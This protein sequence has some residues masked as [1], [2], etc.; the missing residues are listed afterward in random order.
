MLL[1]LVLVADIIIGFFAFYNPDRGFVFDWLA[2]GQVSQTINVPAEPKPAAEPTI[3]LP[4]YEQKLTEL[5]ARGLD[6]LE[7]DLEQMRLRFYRQ[8]RL[9]HESAISAKGDPQEWGGS[10]VGLYKI[11]RGYKQAFSGLAEV[12]M[13]FAL[14]YYGKYYLH[15]EPFYPSGTK[16]VSEFSGGCISQTDQDAEFTYNNVDI[17]MP[18]L[19]VDKNKDE[20]EYTPSE[21]A[22][23][24]EISAAS[25]L[26]ADLDSGFVFGQKEQAT[27]RPIASLTKLMTAAVVVESLDL[28]KRI[29]AS[30]E[31]LTAYGETAG[32]TAGSRYGLVELLYPLLIQSSNDA[33][34]VLGGFLGRA[35]TLRKMDEKA[36]AIMMPDTKFSDL[37]GFDPGNISSAQ[38]L[39]YLA[40]YILNNRPLLW[41]ITRGQLVRSFGEVQF[42]LAKLWNK[43]IFAGDPTFI[44]GKTGYI[45]ASGYNSLFIFRLA[46]PQGQQRNVAII[47]LG[48]AGL[49]LSKTETQKIYR[50]LLDNYFDPTQPQLEIPVEQP[51]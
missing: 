38:D 27:V 6:F 44:G 19:V 51:R 4:L 45:K 49:E 35:N 48:G 28:R 42:E 25:Y 26:V 14:S 1:G 31:Q 47:M 40:R 32:L 2:A 41:E 5:K 34:E 20:F 33:A 23:F 39:F 18:V 21:T 22:T 24:P 43:N 7:A 17:G 16:M 9:Y 50:W 8:G 10:A 13:P 36:Q 12:Y 30:A 46:T 3:Y 29:T 15:G 11:L 37:S